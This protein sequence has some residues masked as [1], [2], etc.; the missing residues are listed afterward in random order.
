M[1][2]QLVVAKLNQDLASD[3][4]IYHA[5]SKQTVYLVSPMAFNHIA[6][7]IPLSNY[8]ANIEGRL[9]VKFATT[10]WVNTT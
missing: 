5:R 6:T 8:S 10:K 9:H 3:L 2:R 7:R 4:F 1:V